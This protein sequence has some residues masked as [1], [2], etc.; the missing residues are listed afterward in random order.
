M[1]ELIDTGAKLASE[2]GDQIMTNDIKAKT[3]PESVINQKSADVDDDDED[4]EDE[5]NGESEGADATGTKKK[6]K[7]KKNKKKKSTA[8]AGSKPPCSRNLSGFSDYY[9]KYGQTDPP[10]KVVAELFLLGQFP[11][12]EI[13]PHSVTKKPVELSNSTKRVSNEEKR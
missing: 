7:K 3:G 10:T 2:T 1:A 12:G 13:Q 11:E 4:E 9:L 8:A 5:V 6:K